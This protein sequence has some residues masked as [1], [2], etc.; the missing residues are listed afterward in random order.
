MVG[1]GWWVCGGV[2]R[3]LSMFALLQMVRLE[4]SSTIDPHLFLELFEVAIVM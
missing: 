4:D 1:G 3:D 2:L